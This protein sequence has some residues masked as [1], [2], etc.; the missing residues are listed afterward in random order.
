[1]RPLARRI[2]VRQLAASAG[3]VAV[4]LAAAALSGCGSSHKSSSSST[5]SATT[6]TATTSAPAGSKASYIAQANAICHE[7]EKQLSAVAANPHELVAKIS[8]AAA[9]GASSN[10]RLRALSAPAGDNTPKLWLRYRE[11]Q[12]ADAQRL[13]EVAPN[14]RS[15]A[16]TAELTDKTR[17]RALA[18]A[19]GLT[20]CANN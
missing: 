15:A 14:V 18:R 8:E 9:V 6:A 1:V 20:V 10:A 17:A 7:F 2:A 13:A 3:A 19:Y 4:A 5:G 12:F 16:S 11:R